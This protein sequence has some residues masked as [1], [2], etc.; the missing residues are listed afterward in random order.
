MTVRKIQYSGRVFKRSL[1]LDGVKGANLGDSVFTVFLVNIFDH[2][3][4]PAVVE[5]NIDIGHSLAVGIEETFEDQ[6]VLDWVKSGNAKSVG[7]NR[8]S[9]RTAAWPHLDATVFGPVDE[10]RHH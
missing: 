1:G 8:S 2:F 9:G 6:A 5:V 3:T 4:T 10:I 7:N